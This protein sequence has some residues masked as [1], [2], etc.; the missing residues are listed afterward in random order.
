M[1]EINKL[2]KDSG[3]SKKWIAEKINMPY[4]TLIAVLNGHR[5]LKEDVIKKIKKAIS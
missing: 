5:T 4:A 2:I 3:R 1:K